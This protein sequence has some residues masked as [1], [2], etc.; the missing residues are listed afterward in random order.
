MADIRKGAKADSRV[1]TLAR[2]RLLRAFA[3]AYQGLR[4]TWEHEANFRI[5]VAIGALALGTGI[6]LNV[7]LVPL[8]LCYLLVLVLELLNSAVEATIDLLSPGHHPLAKRAKDVAAA[9]VLLGALGSVLIGLLVLGP[10]LWQKLI[11]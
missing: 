1:G 6:W 11:G 5:E 10:P 2:N 7:N 4:Y 8:L 9:A 3:Y